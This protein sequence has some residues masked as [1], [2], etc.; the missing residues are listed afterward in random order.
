MTLIL[1]IS[2]SFGH[3]YLSQNFRVRAEI[4]ASTMGRDSLTS[5]LV[6]A[7]RPVRLHSRSANDL[8]MVLADDLGR[9][10][11]GDKVQVEAA[12]NGSICQFALL[13]QP[14]LAMRVTSIHAMGCGR[15]I[16]ISSLQ[17]HGVRIVT[18]HVDDLIIV[19]VVRIPE[20]LSK[21]LPQAE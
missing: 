14:V 8:C 1:Q 21:V 17:V 6:E 16:A 18:I 2:T 7:Q 11:T 13:Q 4:H 12:T 3:A 9:R 19:Q 10:G 15:S 20:S 5:D